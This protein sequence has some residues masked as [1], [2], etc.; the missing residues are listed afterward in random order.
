[1]EI[2]ELLEIVSRDEDS[3]HQFKSD[4]TNDVSL[5]QE[6]VAF[7]NSGGGDIFIGVNDRGGFS[8]LSR[9]DMGRIN[10][11][12]SNAASQQVRP[13][14]NP[15]T[16]NI[17]TTD[18]L[19]IRLV[20]LDGISKPYMDKNGTIWI[21]SGADKRKATSREEMQ[22]IF[23]SSWL[24]HADEIPVN[25]MSIEDVDAGYFKEFLEHNFEGLDELKNNKLV[26]MLQNMNLMK[27]ETLNLSGALLFAKNPVFK[28]PAF[29]IKA[30]TFPGNDIDAS[31]YI[32]SREITGK[33]AVTFKEGMSFIGVNIHH[34][35]NGQGV[36]S[37]G[38]WE[39]SQI[40]FE[41][42]LVNALI[43]RDYFISA[44]IRIFIFKNRIEIISPGCL[45]NNLTV[46]NIKR[47][48][49]NIRNPILASFATRLLPY[50]GL[51][52]G[53]SR[54][55]KEYSGIDFYD[56]HEA[57]LFKVTLNRHPF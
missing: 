12:I 11:I 8:G 4:V 29:V 53:I 20:I 48:N 40:V 42:L 43:H 26:S 56:D 18:G 21:K 16:E 27:D 1:M 9:Q 57:N 34:V 36:N 10:Q 6:M 52:S 33:I 28:L 54:A 23:Q 22:R 25:G 14:I 31:E 15:Q 35:Q 17:A 7:S 41:E 3:K 2:E 13:P 49:S 55:I 45:P 37:I 46:E 19:V 38:K 47:G 32:D 30:I 5:S 44:P 50:R 24:V 51:G 39:I